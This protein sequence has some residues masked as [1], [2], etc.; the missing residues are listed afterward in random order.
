MDV[1][2]LADNDEKSLSIGLRIW[3]MK[4]LERNLVDNIL[5]SEV[6]LGNASAIM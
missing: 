3:V 1:P 5:E 6:K 4:K 2:R